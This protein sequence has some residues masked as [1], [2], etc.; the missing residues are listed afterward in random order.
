MIEVEALAVRYGA[1]EVFQDVSL[2]VDDGRI[3]A[4][5]GNNGAGKTTLLRALS[6]ILGGQGG[7]VVAGTAHGEGLDLTRSRAD[8]IV[9]SG[10]VQVPEGRRVFG[11][12]S[13]EDNL[14]AG[15]LSVRSRPQARRTRAWVHELFPILAD[16]A[17]QPA[18]LLSGGEQQMLAIGRA[19]MSSP[20]VL[21]MDEPSLGIAPLVARQIM[22]TVREVNRA[23]T[24][25]LLVEQNTKL[26]L[27]VAHHA[28][29]MHGGAIVAE[30][31]ADELA[32]SDLLL[33]VSLGKH[34]A[35]AVPTGGSPHG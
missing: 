16:R 10:I 14:A 24:S 31:P 34:T 19:L 5:L 17:Q 28:Y 3:V 13:V 8:R 15:A 23:G 26:A 11:Q 22:E 25:V 35:S 27:S 1:A 18:A 2:R 7:R 33:E 12:L 9:R 6:G 20:R 21:L 32:T 4:L 30:G 29:L